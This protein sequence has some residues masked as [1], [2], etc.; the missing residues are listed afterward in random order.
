MSEGHQGH[1]VELARRRRHQS[2]GTRLGAR[3]GT[4]RG[5][6]DRG[7]RG[8]SERGEI[9]LVAGEGAGVQSARGGGGSV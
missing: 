1:H 5:E 3:G 8:R 7:E 6:R 9:T 2:R 4:E